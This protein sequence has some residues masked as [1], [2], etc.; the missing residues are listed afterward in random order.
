MPGL[1]TLQAAA[2]PLRAKVIDPTRCIGRPVC[3][4][5]C[6]YDATFIN[7][8]DHSAEKCNF[9]AHRL[10]VGLEP[11]CVVVCSTQELM[12]DDLNDP[13]AEVSR[14]VQ[15]DAAQVRRPEKETRPKVFYRGADGVTLDPLA[16]ARPD[17]GLFMWC[18]QGAPTSRR[19]WSSTW[20]SRWVRP[21][22]AT[23]LPTRGWRPG[24]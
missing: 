6:P 18:G 1:Q 19:R 3:T 8:E 2:P 10:D 7:P 20:S 16:A 24:T 12:V 15:Q 21:R 9:C 22:C 11:V 13:D 23:P 14:I 17:G 4:T 5:A